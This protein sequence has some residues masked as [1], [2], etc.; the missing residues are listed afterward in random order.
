MERG[1]LQAV[2]LPGGALWVPGE[3]AGELAAVLRTASG[4]PAPASVRQVRPSRALMALADAAATAAVEHQAAKHRAAAAVDPSPAVRVFLLADQDA[5]S[6]AVVTVAEAADR[7]DLTCERVRQLAVA[8]RIAGRRTSRRVWLLDPVSV[9]AYT[10]HSRRK[11][12]NAEDYDAPSA[13]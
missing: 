5:E 3:L 7:L 2:P 1:R 8:G 4:P 12:S 10:P 9:A 6:S 13:A 11:A